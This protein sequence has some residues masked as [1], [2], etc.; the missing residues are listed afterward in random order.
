MSNKSDGCEGGTHRLDYNSLP[1]ATHTR[2]LGADITVYQRANYQQ[3]HEGRHNGGLYGVDIEATGERQVRQR[4]RK[5]I[6]AWAR[7]TLF[8]VRDD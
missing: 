2:V 8:R 1:I 6:A 4:D 5:Y 7:R 3:V